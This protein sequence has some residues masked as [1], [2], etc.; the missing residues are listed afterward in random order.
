M[1]KLLVIGF[2][3]GVFIFVGRHFFLGESEPM[4]FDTQELSPPLDQLAESIEDQNSEGRT[5]GPVAVN[6][7]SSRMGFENPNRDHKHVPDQLLGWMVTHLYG[8]RGTQEIADYLEASEVMV[9]DVEE[10]IILSLEERDQLCHSIGYPQQCQLLESY[11]RLE[12]H[13]QSLRDTLELSAD[14]RVRL[15]LESMIE[16]DERR[17]LAIKQNLSGET[18]NPKGFPAYKSLIVQLADLESFLHRRAYM[19]RQ[20]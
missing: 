19:R 14:H 3:L 12:H 6:D 5:P 15:S 20:I 16:R 13:L 11:F 4:S 2:V 17:L 18:L 9:A 10:E 7:H 8:Y 1:R